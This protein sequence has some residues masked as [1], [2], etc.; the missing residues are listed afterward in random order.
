MH[1]FSPEDGPLR[2]TG[3]YGLWSES[4][5]TILFHHGRSSRKLIRWCSF[6]EESATREICDTVSGAGGETTAHLFI[7]VQEF[8]LRSR[9]ARGL[10][11][12]GQGVVAG[13]PEWEPAGIACGRRWI[14]CNKD[15]CTCPCEG[16]EDLALQVWRCG[17]ENALFAK[18]NFRDDLHS[19][20]TRPMSLGHARQP[21][22][23]ITRL[24]AK[25]VQSLGDFPVE[26][27]RLCENGEYV[28]GGGFCD[29]QSRHREDCQDQCGGASWVE[30]WRA[31]QHT[32]ESCDPEQQEEGCDIPSLHK[33][34]RIAGTSNQ[35]RHP[36]I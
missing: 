8:F 23:L 21:C 9:L 20:E 28:R 17:P 14:F 19:G 11:R 7:K 3:R 4:S 26:M 24:D 10:G 18:G 22:H 34:Q 32:G 1:G 31:C 6:A 15:L 25:I 16:S 27:H 29:S 5:G 12:E 33:D 35:R 2:T 13:R 36:E 30:L